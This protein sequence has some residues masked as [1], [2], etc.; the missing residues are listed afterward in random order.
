[1]CKVL[2][3]LPGARPTV[4]NNCYDFHQITGCLD[5][6]VCSLTSHQLVHSVLSS[7]CS[8]SHVVTLPHPPQVPISAQPAEAL[9]RAY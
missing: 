3:T 5:P 6:S 1:M 4:T 2:E 8:L 7:C 9:P